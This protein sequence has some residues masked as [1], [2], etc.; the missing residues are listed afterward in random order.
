MSGRGAV[1]LLIAGIARRAGWFSVPDP[2]P[3]VVASKFSFVAI[4]AIVT[5]VAVPV[6]LRAVF[7]P[8]GSEAK[9]AVLTADQSSQA[10]ARILTGCGR[11]TRSWM[12]PSTGEGAAIVPGGSRRIGMAVVGESIVEMT[13]A[14]TSAF[15]SICR[16]Q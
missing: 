6:L 3:P 14:L 9:E 5:T 8:V 1:E 15:G 4:L 11:A 12:L 2:P 16:L 13:R 10:T 7:A